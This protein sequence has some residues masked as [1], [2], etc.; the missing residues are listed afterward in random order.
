MEKIGQ[1]LKARELAAEY[2]FTDVDDH[3]AGIPRRPPAWGRPPA[4]MR[5]SS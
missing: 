3:P 1:R 4:V 2:R 5:R